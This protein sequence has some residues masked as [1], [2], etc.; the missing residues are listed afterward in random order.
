MKQFKASDE[1][2]HKEI[3]RIYD[4][5]K[6]SGQ[7]PEVRFVDL[8]VKIIRIIYYGKELRQ[9]MEKQLTWSLRESADHFDD[10]LVV[11]C[12][13]TVIE[14]EPE[15]V[16]GFNLQ[17]KQMITINEPEGFIK[18]YDA[19]TRTYYFCVPDLSPEEFIKQGHIFAQ[20]FYQMLK[21]PD[22]NL[23]HGACVGI[24][25]K[26][27]LF[28]ARGQR[29]K[30]TLSVL[31]MLEGF[32][33]VSDDYLVLAREADGLY[34]YPIYSI[35]TLSP[36]M[37]NELYDDLEGTR[38][39]SNNSRKDKYVINIANHHDRFRAHYPVKVCMFPEIVSDPEPS[40]TVC[41][42][43]TKGRAITNLAHSTMMQM[44]DL[45]DQATTRKIMSMVSNYEFYHIRLC[46][47][48]HKNV[49]VLRDFLKNK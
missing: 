47:D 33:Y 31:A 49:A 22:A 40:I 29:G 38:F 27:V 23:V 25:G 28:C 19:L 42:P 11:W 41:N 13:P 34:T 16:Q 35:I 17:M 4:R 20:H 48:L 10:T 39:I 44:G 21:M 24:D 26:G 1:V 6:S 12:D 45:K 36:T 32:E 7:T 2:L 3:E 14:R 37:Y 46:R 18:C 8:G 15:I 30:S 5:V 43:A 9:M